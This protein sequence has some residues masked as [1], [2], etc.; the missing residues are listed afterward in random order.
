MKTSQTTLRSLLK[1]M[2][3]GFLGSI[4]IQA[5]NGISKSSEHFPC[6]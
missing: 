4:V 6:A 3:I 5:L 1:E 2:V